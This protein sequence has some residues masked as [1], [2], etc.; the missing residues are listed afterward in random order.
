[1][2]TNSVPETARDLCW[3]EAP[4]VAES[5]Y[6]AFYD[7]IGR[8]GGVTGAAATNSSGRGGTIDLQHASARDSAASAR[9]SATTTARDSASSS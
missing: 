9:D 1:M 8:R 5:N 7:G 3:Y 4:T 2:E 6:G